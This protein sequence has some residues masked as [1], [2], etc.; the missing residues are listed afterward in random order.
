MNAVRA[1]HAPLALIADDDVVIRMFARE[2]LEQAGWLVAE[3]ENGHLAYE[4]F[5]RCTP[6]VVLLDVMMP[7]MDGFTTCER[8]RRLPSGEHI[9]ILIM[10]G[11]DDFES[12]TKAYDAGATDFIVKPLNAVLLTH[13]IRYMVR[14]SQILAELRASQATLTQA[15]DAALEG[16]KLKSEFLA[17][18]S[19]E[20][21]TPMNGVL[22]MTDWLLETDLTAEQRDCAETIRS[23]GDALLVIVND[24][25]D[26]SKIE[27]GKLI[28]ETLDLDLPLFI[29]RMLVLFAERA[30]RKGLRLS[31]RISD[32]VPSLLR[33][34]PGRL[35]QVLSNLIGNAIKF[36]ERGEV[37][38]QV[39]LASDNQESPH[40]T[41]STTPRPSDTRMARLRF[42]VTDTGIGIPSSA[43][44][45]LFQPFVQADGST[46]R[47]YGGTGLGLAI[48]KQLVELMGG[49]IGA[50]SEQGKGS[51]FRFTVPLEVRL[52]SSSTH[53]AA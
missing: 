17:T 53:L 13:R 39:D 2:T 30:R 4:T 52:P 16:A 26:F 19:H 22:G 47:K 6:D 42:S 37:S 25:L 31:S 46:T 3:A 11:R 41:G 7:E 28:L 35:Q 49:H 27:S 29:D 45:K 15:R 38:V 33:G 32:R 40:I 1:D 18:M 48:C 34:D 5:Q 21:R 8:L 43:F 50:E 23:S 44:Q 10:T 12:I 24:I 36:T 51:I 9:P 20:I 14:A